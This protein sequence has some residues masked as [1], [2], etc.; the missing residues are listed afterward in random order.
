MKQFDGA[1]SCVEIVAPNE[2]FHCLQTTIAQGTGAHR[3]IAA[4]PV[5]YRERKE[6]YNGTDFGL[7]PGLIKE[8]IFR[9]QNEGRILWEFESGV[10]RY[11]PFLSGHW[12]LGSYCRE[13]Q[14]N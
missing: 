3:V 2:F 11:E 5:E 14:L 4:R 1:D 8:H 7:H 9:S 12:K 13:I 10:Q 6:I